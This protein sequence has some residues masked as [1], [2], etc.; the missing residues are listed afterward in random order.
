[1]PSSDEP[2]TNMTVNIGDSTTEITIISPGGMV[3]SKSIPVA[4][5]EFD[6]AIIGYMKRAY[7]LLIGERTA[8]EIK[9][10]IGSA[11]PLDEELSMEA[12]GRD[13]MAGLP[14]TIHLT[15][16]EI[17][18]ALNDTISAIVDA[19]RSAL[20]SC[21]PEFSADL[22][23]RGFVLAGG[24]SLVRGIDHLLSEKTGLHVIVAKEK[25]AG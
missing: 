19:V 25:S 20:E 16:Q 1:M 17:R 23:D 3:L 12:K 14:T 21:P 4:G 6:N 15:S 9:M 11:H 10:R 2:A 24:R 7:D 18:E 22:V 5:D 8:R 13:A